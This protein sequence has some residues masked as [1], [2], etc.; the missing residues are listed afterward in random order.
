MENRLCDENSQLL[1][2]LK[3]FNKSSWPTE[4]DIRLGEPEVRRLS[5]R[6]NLNSQNAIMGMR[7]YVEC[8]IISENFKEI[9]EC[10]MTLACSTAECER[11]F[12][13]MN[14]ICTDIRNSLLIENISNLMF[15]N[16][17][18]PMN[19]VYKILATNS[20][21]S[22]RQSNKATNTPY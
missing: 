17:N 2:D 15:I 21:S 14:M 12:S 11:G 6:F 5:Q 3:V 18:G 20:S 4:P 22:G 19:G 1:S 7:D 8:D 10:S 13:L 16:M 9:Y